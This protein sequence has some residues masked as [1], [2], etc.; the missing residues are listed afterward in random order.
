M[1]VIIAILLLNFS[2]STLIFIIKRVRIKLYQSNIKYKRVWK[3]TIN[4]LNREE[5]EKLPPLLTPQELSKILGISVPFCYTLIRSKGFPSFRVGKKWI[6]A[7]DK[8]MAWIDL[9]TSSDE[10]KH[11]K[12]V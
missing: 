6:I 7:T 1:R 12:R 3:G 8:L 11:I 2:K 9:Q 5:I 4:M 10:Y